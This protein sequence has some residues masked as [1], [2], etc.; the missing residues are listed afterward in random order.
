MRMTCIS[1]GLNLLLI[2]F[3]V[4]EYSIKGEVTMSDRPIEIEG[5]NDVTDSFAAC[6]CAALNTWGKPES[7]DFVMGLTG[8]A[9]TLVQVLDENCT[10][11]WM[12]G[13]SD[14]HIEFLGKALGFSVESHKRTGNVDWKEA[15][16]AYAKT[17]KWPPAVSSYLETLKSGLRDNKIVIVRTWP[18]W[19]ILTSWSDDEIDLPFETIPGLNS[20]LKK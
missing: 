18:S 13:G 4:P 19:S 20:P 9:F 11:W 5:K 14:I 15:E 17:G 1:I 12:E 8:A 3:L 7:Y 2:A 10:A 16:A 6:I